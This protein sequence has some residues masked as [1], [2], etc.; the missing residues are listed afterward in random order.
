M[1]WFGVIQW[2]DWSTLAMRK[3]TVQVVVTVMAHLVGMAVEVMVGVALEV[4]V[5]VMVEVMVKVA[6]AHQ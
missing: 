5:E 4:V 3:T 6:V 1:V 2:E